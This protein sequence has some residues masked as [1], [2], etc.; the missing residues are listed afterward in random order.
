MPSYRDIMVVSGI[1]LRQAEENLEVLKTDFMHEL[2]AEIAILGEV[3]KAQDR[4]RS[5]ALAYSLKAVAAPLD[6]PL[7]S[8][9]ADMLWRVIRFVPKDA[10]FKE[11]TGY[12]FDTMTLLVRGRHSGESKTGRALITGLRTLFDKHRGIWTAR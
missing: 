3:L 9:A 1:L 5:Q 2:P 7:I 11:I 4:T 12:Y 6:W 8:E 10:N